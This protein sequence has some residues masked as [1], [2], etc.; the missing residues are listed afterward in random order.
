MDNRKSGHIIKTG[1]T[2]LNFD[3]NPI[4]NKVLDMLYTHPGKIFRV[5]DFDVDVSLNTYNQYTNYLIKEYSDIYRIYKGLSSVGI[6]YLPDATN[7]DSDSILSKLYELKQYAD[8]M[9]KTIHD[10]LQDEIGSR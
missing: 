6:A 2:V 7:I 10:V 1:N 4:L 9:S 5:D 3:T 8:N